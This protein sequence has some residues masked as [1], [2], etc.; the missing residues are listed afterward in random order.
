MTSD[1]SFIGGELSIR[2]PC[3]PRPATGTESYRRARAERRRRRKQDG[4]AT[5]DPRGN[6]L[7]LR[8]QVVGHVPRAPLQPRSCCHRLRPMA[9]SVGPSVRRDE[10][11]EAR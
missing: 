10:A 1:K 4:R 8:G 5:D 2:Y 3:Q 9:V 6:G 7:K 11:R